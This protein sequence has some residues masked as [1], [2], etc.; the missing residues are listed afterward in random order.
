MR[1][2]LIA[3]SLFALAASSVALAQAPA[4]P[5]APSAAPAAEPEASAPA[6]PP[7]ATSAAPAPEA[8]TAPVV[9]DAVPAAPPPSA[10]QPEP[11]PT[12]VPSAPTEPAPPVSLP[13][14]PPPTAPQ[15]AGPRS[16]APP[17][18]EEFAS[19]A[20]EPV[21]GRTLYIRLAAGIGFPFG[22]DVADRYD[23]RGAGAL[24]FSGYSFAI[25][26][27]A[28]SAVLPWLVVG[29]GVA[30]DTVGGG[31]VRTSS[32]STRSI[33]HSLYYAVVG[34]F[35]DLYTAPPSGLHFQALL[36]VARLSR[37]DDLGHDTAVGFGAVLGAG[38][39]LPVGRRWN[40]GALARIAISPM[41]MHGVAGQRPSPIFY[42]PS[43]LWTATFRPER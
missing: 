16:P 13:V 15:A 4:Q 20:T 7:V 21:R 2:I 35:A 8:T 18:A 43:L 38:Y 27:M 14:A 29:G 41:S 37:A 28:G 40:F 32:Q 23:D 17:S 19:E 30:S 33:E 31:S 39:E 26:A 11:A 36:G 3:A 34:G 1:A 42:E 25:D 5:A 10:A 12:A 9:P 22:S 6:A 24:H